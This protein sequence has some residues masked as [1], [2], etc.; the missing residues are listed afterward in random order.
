MRIHQLTLK[1]FRGFENQVF[2]LNPS[3]TAAIGDNGTGKSTLLH[4]LQVATGAY[5]LGLPHVYRRHI[6]DDEIRITFNS[7][8]KQ[9]EH[10]TP[11]FVEVEGEINGSGKMIWRRTIP[12]YGKNTSSKKADVGNIKSLAEK[13]AR[14]INKD[15]RPML[16]VI[17]FFG[18]Q[19]MGSKVARRKRSKSKRILIR[20]GYYNALGQKSDESAFTEWLYNYDNSLGAGAEFSGTREAMYE[21]IEKAIPYLKN[22]DFNRYYF[23][24]EADVCIEGQPERRLIHQHMS[25][26]VKR[27]LGIVADIAYRCVTLNGFKGKNA[28][29][30]SEGIVMIDELDMHLHPNWQ[31]QIVSDLKSAFPKIQFVVTTHSPFI[32]QSLNSDELINLDIVSDISYKDLP[33]QIIATK[34]MGVESE[35]SEENQSKYSIAKKILN[36]NENPQEITLETI[37]NG[38]DILIYT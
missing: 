26:G 19:Q 8:S 3:F 22:L 9:Y 14:D 37:K 21:A 20:D 11:T 28:V 12:E 6:S 4:A 16:P 13:Y 31:R 18:V 27:I 15:N 38:N 23:Q 7:S 30:E 33:V 10:Q 29:V 5:F 17:A 35:F 36:K 32:V 1:N 2:R 24:F 25:D 34:V